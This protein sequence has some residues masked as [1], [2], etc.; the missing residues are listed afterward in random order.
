MYL[1]KEFLLG[2]ARTRQ[3]SKKILLWCRSST[4][5]WLISSCGWMMAS[6][7]KEEDL[8]L[9][10]WQ[11]MRKKKNTLLPMDDHHLLTRR[12]YPKKF[13]QKHYS[14][15]GN[16]DSWILRLDMIWN[17]LHRRDLKGNIHTQ[18]DLNLLLSNIP[19]IQACKYIYILISQDCWLLME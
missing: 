10:P 19:N 8:T 14:G 12:L 2:R 15:F 4:P 9:N 3:D 7:P 16:P 18:P 1:D 11:K 6:P 13:L 5:I 17:H